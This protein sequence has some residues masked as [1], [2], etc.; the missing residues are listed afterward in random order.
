V[1]STAGN[2]EKFGEG[3]LP[4]EQFASRL[5]I[6]HFDHFERGA[7]DQVSAEDLERVVGYVHR[8]WGVD[9]V[10]AGELQA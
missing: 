1:V 4:F 2:G 3:S 9:R 5:Y 6:Y 8:S 7:P 10:P